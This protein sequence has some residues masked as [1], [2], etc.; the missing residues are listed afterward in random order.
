MQYAIYIMHYPFPNFISYGP[1]L[2]I[3][4]YGL[5]QEGHIPNMHHIRCEG[6]IPN[7]TKR[8]RVRRTYSKK[9]LLKSNCFKPSTRKPSHKHYIRRN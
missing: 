5:V 8:D 9:S 7:T 1:N 2:T 3:D 4:G 6:R